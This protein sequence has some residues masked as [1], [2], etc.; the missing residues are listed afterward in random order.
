MSDRLLTAAEVAELLSL[1]VSW[2]RGHTRTGAIPHVP[3]GRYVRYERAEVLAWV[4]SLR[5]GGGPRFRRH[6]P[7]VARP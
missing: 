3:L 1:P 5:A 4:D 6:E 2:V 7:K